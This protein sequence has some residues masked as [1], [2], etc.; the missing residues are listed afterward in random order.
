[1][2]FLIFRQK[3]ILLTMTLPAVPP[4]LRNIG[5]FSLVLS[6]AH[7]LSTELIADEF[8]TR[9]AE[10]EREHRGDEKDAGNDDDDDPRS[11]PH[12]D[13]GDF[14]GGGSSS[15]SVD[16]TPHVF[17]VVSFL[18][19][20]RSSRVFLARRVSSEKEGTPAGSDFAAVKVFRCDESLQDSMYYECEML[21][22]LSETSA[23][24]FVSRIL[25]P[26]F[27]HIG[28]SEGTIEA[29]RDTSKTT[30]PENCLQ[31]FPC[32]ACEVLGPSVDS[33]MER[34]HFRGVTDLAAVKEI[35]RSTCRGLSALR[36]L[37]IMHCDIKPE[38]LLFA[39]PSDAVM[40]TM[41]K[42]NYGNKV[43]G[44]NQPS[45][46]ESGDGYFVKLTDFGLSYI[47][48]TTVIAQRP[49]PESTTTTSSSSLLPALMQER[50][51]CLEEL[52]AYQQ[53]SIVATREYRAPE[54]ILG[55]SLD[56]P[57]DVWSVGCIAYELVTG[58][59]L[60]DPKVHPLAVDEHAMDSVH[61]ALIE[62]L[63]GTPPLRYLTR[64]VGSAVYL[65]NF[66]H[67]D[68]LQNVPLFQAGQ[69]A[70]LTPAAFHEALA[71]NASM[72]HDSRELEH[73]SNF[74]FKC[75]QWDPYDRP[76]PQLLLEHP[77]LAQ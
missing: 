45:A 13:D 44:E 63:C 3:K 39:K 41:R 47:V 56:C 60:F 21:L 35:I 66:V 53:G 69:D 42:A 8:V 54:V 2:V 6:L 76:P 31:Q 52:G 29:Q 32:F 68:D 4:R 55:D 62:S 65:Q 40:E 20:G 1:M 5:A 46:D 7:F 23:A 9:V 48:P 19:E 36:E 15:S 16:D 59:I 50:L 61:L 58:R 75:L 26:S 43:S 34:Y 67:P 49:R 24:P 33:L 18:G 22:F 77:W 28:P 27:Q 12:I 10:C 74:I 11:L 70:P 71:Q 64:C 37:N 38:N 73:A 72:L 14:I 57:L 25:G 51:A 17:Q 30:S